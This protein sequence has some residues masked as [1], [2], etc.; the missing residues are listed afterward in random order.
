MTARVR[1]AVRVALPAWVVG[2][3]LSLACLGIV[4][5]THGGHTPRAGGVHVPGSHGWF[6]WD[7]A[8]YRLIAERGYLASPPGGVRFFPLFPDRKS[9]RLNSS[10]AN[11]SYAVFCLKKKN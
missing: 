2:R 7:A 5:L 8:W 6:A 10:H 3:L 9:T 4:V 11:T 1:G